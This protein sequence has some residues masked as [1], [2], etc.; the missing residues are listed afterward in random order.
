MTPLFNWKSRN[1]NNFEVFTAIVCT[2]GGVTALKIITQPYSVTRDPLQD[3]VNCINFWD[4]CSEQTKHEIGFLQVIF[5]NNGSLILFRFFT[6]IPVNSKLHNH[7]NI[8]FDMKEGYYECSGF[9]IGWSFT[10]Y[11]WTKSVYT[12]WLAVILTSLTYK[13]PPLYLFVDEL[14]EVDD[15]FH[16]YP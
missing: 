14:F 9:L 16:F 12:Q 1:L 10:T 11:H 4:F 13:Q 6:F 8:T 2:N 15:C 3:S 5:E 7:R